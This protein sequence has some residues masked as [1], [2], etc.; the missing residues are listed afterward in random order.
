RV[1]L[2]GRYNRS[3]STTESGFSQVEHFHLGTSNITLGVTAMPTP[4]VTNDVRL[5]FWRTRADASWAYDPSAGGSPID[6]ASFLH[7]SPNAGPAFYA[8]AVGGISALFSG[9]SGRNS[10]SQWNL[11]ETLTANG[12]SHSWRVGVD[13]ERLTPVRESA[14]QAVS[15]TWNSL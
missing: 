3:P 9:S 14:A 10:Q 13:Y 4:H 12:L 1:S 2:F 6:L 7:A 15:G 8:V 11:V 5:S